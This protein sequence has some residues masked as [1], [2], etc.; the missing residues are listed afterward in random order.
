SR[1]RDRYGRVHTVRNG[2]VSNVINYSRGWTLAVIEIGVAFESELSEVFR[3]LTEAGKA[4]HGK[5]PEQVFEPS[6]VMGVAA[7]DESCLRVRVETRV[8]PGCH[9]AAKN[10]L[11]R[12][13]L[14]GFVANGIE[15]P[16]PKGVEFEGVPRHPRW[17]EPDD[18]PPGPS[19]AA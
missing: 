17:P 18:S 7:I 12:L 4:L 8:R 14:E 13:I 15:I 2:D 5:L 11:N 9:F 6:Q 16:Y 19:P 10:E 3:V 1:I